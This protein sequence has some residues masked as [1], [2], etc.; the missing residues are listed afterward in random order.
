MH[1]SIVALE[2]RYYLDIE[3]SINNCF[4]IVLTNISEKE[5]QKQL[6]YVKKII[7]TEIYI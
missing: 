7:V 5:I 3:H 6:E 2:P 4:D 1:N